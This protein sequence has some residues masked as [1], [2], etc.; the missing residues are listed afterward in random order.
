MIVTPESWEYL[1][2]AVGSEDS[3]SKTLNGDHGGLVN[4]M[5]CPCIVIL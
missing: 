4:W 5:P 2:P 1:T 3:S